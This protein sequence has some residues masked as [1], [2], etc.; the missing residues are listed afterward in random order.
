MNKQLNLQIDGE[1]GEPELKPCP[2]CGEAPIIRDL[3]L[4]F[5]VECS[6]LY[7]NCTALTHIARSRKEAIRFWNR[8]AKDD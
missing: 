4:L 1:L 6:N 3:D 5:R 8:R 2:F 7:C